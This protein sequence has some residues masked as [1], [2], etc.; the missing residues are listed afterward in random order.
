MG[1]GERISIQTLIK[2]CKTLNCDIADVIG[3]CRMTT[4]KGER[5]SQ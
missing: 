4:R 5:A 1:K 3:W 2:I